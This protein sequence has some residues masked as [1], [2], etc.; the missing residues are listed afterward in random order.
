MLSDKGDTWPET[1]VEVV[2]CVYHF[3]EEL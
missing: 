2:F 3:T 1:K